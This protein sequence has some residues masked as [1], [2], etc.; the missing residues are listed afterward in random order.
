MRKERDMHRQ[1]WLERLADALDDVAGE[2]IRNEVMQGSD[3]LSSGSSAGKKAAWVRAMIQRMEQRLDPDRRIEVMT[4][5]SCPAAQPQ[6]RR[7]RRI[8]EQTRDV[9]AV[10]GA[11]AESDREW[12][13]R[14]IGT[15][16]ALLR[17]VRAE[18]LY[19][20]PDR[21]GDT[22]RHVVK[23]NHPAEYLTSTD[24]KEKRAHYCHCGWIRYGKEEIPRTFCYCGAGYYKAI[25]EAILDAPVRVMVESSV[26]DGGDYC[27]LAVHLPADLA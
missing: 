15:N 25:W 1:S 9:D 18:P 8:Y 19:R 3:G 23:P 26:F 10:I 5:C 6:I 21:E 24:P 20:G 11:M 27:R 13:R 17:Q 14:R 2:S 16:E 7:L 4:R 12:L 22:V